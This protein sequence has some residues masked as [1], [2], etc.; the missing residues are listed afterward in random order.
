[1]RTHV[2]KML[3]L[4]GLLGLMMA[5]SAT[6]GPAATGLDTGTLSLI[7]PRRTYNVL[8]VKDVIVPSSANSPPREQAVNV[9]DQNSATKYL[10]FDKLDTGF[11]VTPA[12]GAT[13]ITGISLTSANDAPERDPASYLIEGS[14]NG[15]RFDMIAKGTVPRFKDRLTRQTFSFLN[16]KPYT[17]YRVTFPTVSDASTANSM[18]IADVALLGRAYG[19]VT[20]EPYIEQPQFTGMTRNPDRTLTLT[21]TGQGTLQAAPDPAGPFEDI[22][23]ATS[24]YTFLPKDRMKFFQLKTARVD[25]VVQ[26]G[27]GVEIMQVDFGSKFPATEWG[28]LFLD[29]RSLLKN[30]G[31][32]GGYLNVFTKK[33]WAV[34]NLPVPSLDQPPCVKYFELGVP[35]RGTRI[36]GTEIKVFHSNGPVDNAQEQVSK[37]DFSQYVVSEWLWNPA[38]VGRES[39]EVMPDQAPPTLSVRTVFKLVFSVAHYENI[40]NEEAAK[41]QCGPMAVA[42]SLQFLENEGHITVPHN[43]TLGLKGDNTL[44]GRLDTACD[45]SVTARCSGSGVC[46]EEMIEGKFKYLSDN[47]LSTALSHRHQG[48]GAL[49]ALLPSANFTAHGITSQYDGTPLTW[50]W[51]RDRIQDGWAV[52]AWITWAGGGGHVVRVTGCGKRFGIPWL[53]YSHDAQQCNDASGLEDVIVDLSDPDADGRF[54]LDDTNNEI[55]LFVAAGP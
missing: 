1:M 13:I 35:E 34:R 8:S 33:G 5:S 21:W 18:Q 16:T 54:N 23:G 45:R 15:R 42:N 2:R 11:T 17:V 53:R 49:C 32:A 51:L 39:I 3:A 41:N 31:V 46:M 10:N 20:T 28:R 14:D 9:L 50:E 27:K 43:H 24:P 19:A 48:V 55:V 7:E 44:V 37:I 38:G 36:K 40:T 47:G 22:F 52:E 26:P 12:M 25:R 4:I 29:H 6:A 30:T